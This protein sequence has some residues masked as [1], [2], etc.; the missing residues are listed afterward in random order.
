MDISTKTC[1]SRK[2]KQGTRGGEVETEGGE[3]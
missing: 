3:L 2:V 1:T